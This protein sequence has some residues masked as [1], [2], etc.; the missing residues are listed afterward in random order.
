MATNV[1]RTLGLEERTA[2]LAKVPAFAGLPRQVL[3]ALAVKLKQETAE[4]G[5]AI[6]AADEIG[7]RMY[8]VVEGR[9]EVTIAGPEGPILIATLRPGEYFGEMALL[10]QS[11]LRSATVTAAT[12]ML[13]L[14][15]YGSVFHET[16]KA[17]PRAARFFEEAAEINLRHQ[18][19]KRSSPFRA[20]DSGRLHELAA[21]LEELKVPAGQA[22][23]RQGER[24]EACYLVR[25]GQVEVVVSTADGVEQTLAR[26]GP[27]MLFGE[28]C[29]LVDAPRTAT[30]RATEPTE[31]L[32][33]KRSVLLR[34]LGED[35]RM[36][37]ELVQRAQLQARPRQRPGIVPDPRTTDDCEVITTLKDAAR[38]AYYQLS[39][40]G[41]FVWDHIDG[42]RTVAEIAQLSASAY[43]E[44]GSPLV[45]ETLA[46][47]AREGF[48]EF[49][50]VRG[51]VLQTLGRAP[52][53]RRVT[54]QPSRLFGWLA[55][56]RG[57]Q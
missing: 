4:A 54:Q 2:V 8:L 15:L 51:D 56:P 34:A 28:T 24:G 13:L 45:L 46:G 27:G 49:P 42:R 32:V 18:F 39:P 5:R 55:G 21:R 57:R 19:L 35:E 40:R 50:A 12:P 7:D 36:G 25:R 52:W 29:L 53:W 41:R 38:G 30:V 9:A 22:I 33:L 37:L 6:V 23:V 11:R 43:G 26:L 1:N 17:H 14:S 16:L 3:D 10:G 20:I 44:D 31:V 47:L 48:V